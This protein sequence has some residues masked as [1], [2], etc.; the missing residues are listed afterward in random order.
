VKT[1][2]RS[3]RPGLFALVLSGCAALPAGPGPALQIDGLDF[4]NRSASPIN[5]IRLLVPATG[6]FVSCGYISPGAS[7]ASGFPG[8]A[9]RAEPVEISWTQGGQ[10]WTTGEITLQA[11]E[12]VARSGA[13]QVMVV[14]LAPGSAGA[15]LVSS[16]RQD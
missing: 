12:Q 5:S 14:V 8:V 10:E 2:L 6:N 15:V 3:V 1:P 16:S 4:E 11:D 7:C 9:Y 13:A